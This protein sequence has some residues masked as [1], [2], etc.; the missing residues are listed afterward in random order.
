MDHGVESRTGTIRKLY[1]RPWTKERIEL[2]A[3]DVCPSNL[4]SSSKQD[5]SSRKNQPTERTSPKGLGTLAGREG[6]VL[7]GKNCRSLH[8]NLTSILS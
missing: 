8:N 3:L 4:M 1:R 6:L 7:V 2:L 5:I